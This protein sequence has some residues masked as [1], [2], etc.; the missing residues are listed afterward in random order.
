[1]KREKIKWR[2]HM[3]LHHVK[4][5][6]KDLLGV[7]PPMDRTFDVEAALRN[8][9]SH[10]SVLCKCPCGYV[11]YPD[12]HNFGC[13]WLKVMCLTCGGTGHCPN[14]LGDGSEPNRTEEEDAV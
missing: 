2:A 9:P 12:E 6:V 8:G 1:M 11:G 4:Y 7:P 5:M 13:E 3:I 10:P 14:C